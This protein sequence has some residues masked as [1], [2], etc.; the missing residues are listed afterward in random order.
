MSLFQSC[1]VRTFFDLASAF[2]AHS[3]K[4]TLFSRASTKPA[5]AITL[6]FSAL[7]AALASPLRAEVLSR[8]ASD[9]SF[10]TIASLYP[11][12]ILYPRCGP[13]AVWCDQPLQRQWRWTSQACL[14]R[15]P[16]LALKQT[17]QYQNLDSFASQRKNCLVILVR[18]LLL[19]PYWPRLLRQYFS[20]RN[21]RLGYHATD[22][23]CCILA[24]QLL[25]HG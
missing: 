10:S 21:R 4:Q 6:L 5:H 15:Q 20:S 14:Y 16:A 19:W 23:R 9:L 8:P 12:Q 1:P 11:L 2:L 24:Q 3:F 17:S 25:A 7:L 18:D 22:Y 13:S